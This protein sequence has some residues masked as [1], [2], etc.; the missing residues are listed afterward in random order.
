MDINDRIAGV[1]ADSRFA[2]PL[3]LTAIA[4]CACFAGAEARIESF[5]PTGHSKSVRQVA[6]RFSEPMVALGDP[7]RAVPFAVDC[8]VPGHGRWVDER[9][10]VYDFEHEVPGA[11]RCQFGVQDG[12][13]T[14]SGERVQ[15]PPEYA[16]H[17]GGPSI[18]AHQPDLRSK[19]DERQVFLLLLDA[20]ADP[21]SVRQHARCR[22]AD[23]AE[24]HPVDL[25]EGTERTEILEALSRY[26]YL[27]TLLSAARKQLPP[28]VDDRTDRRAIERIAMVRCPGPLPSGSDMELIWGAGI[29]APNGLAT[30]QNQTMA[31]SVRP[32]PRASLR[33]MDAFK[34]RCVRGVQVWFSEPIPREFA[35]RVRLT[36]PD[37]RIVPGEIGETIQIDRIDYPDA[38]VEDAT[39]RAEL[40]GPINDIYD[41]SLANASD[42]PASIRLGRW[43]PA[44][45]FGRVPI[46]VEYDGNAMAPVLVRRI[47]QPLAG[48]RLRVAGGD[49][50]IV[51][52]MRRVAGAW[53]TEPDAWRGLASSRSVF[54]PDDKPQGYALPAEASGEPFRFAS[55]PL[56]GRGFHVLELDLP[57]SAD[58][59]ARY[60]AG[61]AVA[62]DLAVH[63]HRAA[64]ASLAW[65]TRLAD[66]RP[67]GGAEVRVS[68]A[69]TGRLL[70]RGATDA[71]GIARIPTAL[72]WGDDCAGFRY[73]VTARK[74]DDL[75]LATFGLPGD[76]QPRPT[77]LFHTILDRSLYRPGETVSMKVIVRRA[78]SDGFELLEGLPTAG[79]VV[80][81]HVATGKKRVVAIDF[82]ADGSAVA[83]FDLPVDARLG[84]YALS[85]EFAGRASPFSY[86]RVEKFRLGAM[87]A[88]VEG[89]DKPVVNPRSVPVGL[90]VEHLAGGGAAGLPVTVRWVVNP[91]SYYW[92]NTTVQPEPVT[93]SATLDAA[94]K[95]TVE[96]PVPALDRRA[97][98]DVEMDYRDA[99][100]QQRTAA[101]YFELWPAEVKLGITGHGTAAG[102]R[103]VRLAVRDP[104]DAPVSDIVV[105]ADVYQPRDVLWRRLPGG[106]PG[107]GASDRVRTPLIARCSGTTGAN[108]TVDCELPPETPTSVFVEATAHDALANEAAAAGN[109]YLSIDDL[110]PEFLEVDSG[111]VFDVGDTVPVHVHLPY[112]EAMALVTVQREGLPT[113]FVTGVSGPQAT[114]EVPVE[115]HYA[116]NFD[117]SVLAIPA[118]SEAAPDPRSVVADP[119]QP[120]RKV[121][122]PEFR[123]GTVSV[124]V[125]PEP[126]ALTVRVEPHR[127]RYR[128]RERARVSITVLGPAGLAARDVDVAL[129]A[130]DEAL[131]ELWPNRDVGSPRSHDAVAFAPGRHDDQFGQSVADI[132]FRRTR[133]ANGVGLGQCPRS[134]PARTGRKRRRDTPPAFRADVALAGPHRVG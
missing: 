113:A 122:R 68:A 45:N 134:R 86:F 11:V 93:M 88:S 9:N 90:S 23:S 17:T 67:V 106:F 92:E 26:Y 25:V 114:V 127:D 28:D 19:I 72:P 71:D 35:D 60:V 98:L 101:D 84:R 39:Y 58:F 61:M 12:L 43:P 27:S 59:A 123:H 132:E 36:D 94:G 115:K 14:L 2:R 22:F 1:P 126:Y 109:V 49:A 80:S 20:L 46:V 41:R 96:V 85:V 4:V 75:A 6:V 124:R 102:V 31:F 118:G 10:W 100:G 89:P 53:N 62:T 16:F 42:F 83:S 38:S 3:L 77:I 33:C 103:L 15:A 121:G 79:R 18:L 107:R 108:G 21:D 74:D 48:S 128:P 69:C 44:A 76:T 133:A 30:L 32:L 55:V 63:F 105:Q 87:R 8:E 104:E 47:A 65:V 29:A 52:W 64:E 7:S 111:R 57:A 110:G 5:S 37:G 56:A 24:E 95:G 81:E 120:M 78:S 34:G 129:V 117:V 73:L 97:M 131:L 40:L 70:A 82:A 13:A 125:N 119:D 91:W 51:A 130:V 99:N 116:P 50:E 66:G 112:T 54:G